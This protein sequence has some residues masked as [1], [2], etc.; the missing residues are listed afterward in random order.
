MASSKT[1]PVIPRRGVLAIGAGLSLVAL[2]PAGSRAENTPTNDAAALIKR[3]IGDQPVVPG[4]LVLDVPEIAEN[5]NTV[6][7]AIKVESPMTEADHVTSVAIFADGNPKAGVITFIF[8]PFSGVA[9][10]GT[11]IRLTGSQTVTAVAR[12]STG[13]VMVAARLIK[14]TI[15][16]C[17]G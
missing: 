11:R 9:E 13:Q 5:G 14:V 6:P 17:G 3:L 7:L 1:C 2:L 10:A 15:G 8:T 4:R 16:G 12:T